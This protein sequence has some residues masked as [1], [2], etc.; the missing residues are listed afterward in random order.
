MIY[1]NFKGS[2]RKSFFLTALTD[3]NTTNTD[4]LKIASKVGSY[5]IN[6]CKAF[7]VKKF[8]KKT[9]LL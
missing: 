2:I 9:E 8:Y 4:L 3:T 7:T 1:Y 6:N 5:W